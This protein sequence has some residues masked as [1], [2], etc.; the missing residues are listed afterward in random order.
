MYPLK[1]NMTIK[2]MCNSN[3]AY[4]DW[5]K[6]ESEKIEKLKNSRKKLKKAREVVSFGEKTGDKR[7]WNAVNSIV[8]RFKGRK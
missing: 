7:I 6:E 5:K 3:R 1:S 8:M 2:E 4:Q